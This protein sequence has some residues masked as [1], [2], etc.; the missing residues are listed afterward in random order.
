MNRETTT[1]L[2]RCL[3][4]YGRQRRIYRHVTDAFRR[5]LLQPEP[6]TGERVQQFMDAT[7]YRERQRYPT[8][9]DY[10]TSF[11]GSPEPRR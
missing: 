8:G 5:S 7:E 6:A 2:A 4:H 11:S 3:E 9:I 10:S 1:K